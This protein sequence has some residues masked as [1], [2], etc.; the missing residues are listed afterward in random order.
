MNKKL[1]KFFFLFF[2]LEMLLG[3]SQ[4]S[5]ASEWKIKRRGYLSARLT[6]YTEEKS[7]NFGQQTRA[8]LEEVTEETSKLSTKLQLRWIS[9]SVSTDIATKS[10]PSKKD[11]FNLYPGE[12]YVKYKSETWVAQL[13]FQEVVWGEAFGL[14]YADIINP[15]DQRETFYN[16][17]SDSRFPLLLLNAKKYFSSESLSGSLQLLYSP[18]PRFSK[19]LPIELYAQNILTQSSL[20]VVKESRPALFKTHEYGA[21]LSTSYA[22]AD[23]S[24]FSFSYLDRDPHYEILSGTLTSL[25]LKEVHNRIQSSGL[26][27]ARPIYDY[28]FRTDIVYTQK[29]MINYVSGFQLLS[30]PTNSLNTLVS[31]DSPTF[32]SYSGVLIF[33][34]STLRDSIAHAVREKNEDYSIFK[35]SKDLGSDRSLEL[36]YTHE[37]SH[38]AH[39]IQTFLN[40]PLATNTELKVG[41]EFYFGDELSNLNKLKNISGVFF[42][43]KNYFQL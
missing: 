8:Q 21:K 1:K 3:H 39:S 40:W 42:S 28:V 35:I 5:I 43:L 36:S 29:K 25:T 33:A 20:A 32:N 37:F 6:S 10:T 16:N 38:S 22:G 30:K 15:K 7:S 2:S 19:T 41:G 18:E 23:F 13:G 24:L 27:F 4:N 14:N 34:R 31:I 9:N 17:A 11:N 26:S 12:T